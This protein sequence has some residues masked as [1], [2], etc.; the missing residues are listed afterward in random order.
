MPKI[1]FDLSREDEKF[2][3][4]SLNRLQLILKNVS[5]WKNDLNEI[6]LYLYSTVY[7]LFKFQIF[8]STYLWYTLFEIEL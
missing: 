4:L 3:K 8:V 6:H 5:R 7:L 1:D 2:K